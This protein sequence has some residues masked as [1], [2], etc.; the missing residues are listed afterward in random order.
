VL[1]LFTNDFRMWNPF[2]YQGLASKSTRGGRRKPHSVTP[3]T[4]REIYT[5]KGLLL[6]KTVLHWNYHLDPVQ[7][8]AG[9][10]FWDILPLPQPDARF[11]LFG[12]NSVR[13]ARV[14]PCPDPLLNLPALFAS[15]SMVLQACCASRTSRA[16]GQ[17]V[18]SSSDR[19]RSGGE[20]RR[21][22]V[23]LRRPCCRPETA[24]LHRRRRERRM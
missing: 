11:L 3:V 9:S 10:R 15:V 22:P 7:G 16:A 21:E 12:A 17:P 13:S 2:L 8:P 20:D 1:A 19:R 4:K 6:P 18:R 24:K 5:R 14:E 23:P